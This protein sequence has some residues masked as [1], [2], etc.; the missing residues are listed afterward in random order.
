MCFD[1]FRY[2]FIEVSPP[3]H[4]SALEFQMVIRAR[5]RARMC[6][7]FDKQQRSHV[8][9]KYEAPLKRKNTRLICVTFC[10]GNTRPWL[11]CVYTLCGCVY[12]KQQVRGGKNLTPPPL[13]DRVSK[14]QTRAAIIRK[15]GTPR[16]ILNYRM[17]WLGSNERIVCMRV[18]WQK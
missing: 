8:V 16:E 17:P 6:K 14:G 5:S 18:C 13:A 4:R 9:R 15:Q 10:G 3:S 2:G 7:C 1:V 12:V 11:C